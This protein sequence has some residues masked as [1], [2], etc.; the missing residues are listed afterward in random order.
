MLTAMLVSG[1]REEEESRSSALSDTPEVW[2]KPILRRALVLLPVVARG[3]VHLAIGL[4]V[5][6]QYSPY[7]RSSI[8]MS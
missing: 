6:Y 8:E 2:Q 3:C 7:I 1:K 5:I 4:L